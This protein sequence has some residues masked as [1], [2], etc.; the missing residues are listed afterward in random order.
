MSW[1]WRQAATNSPRV[2]PLT[3]SDQGNQKPFISQL[4]RRKK[5]WPHSLAF[6]GEFA[7]VGVVGAV[8]DPRQPEAGLDRTVAGLAVEFQL[9]N[10]IAP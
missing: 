5:G 8:D 7:D 2:L 4:K 1:T 9:K 6:V 3:P 10:G